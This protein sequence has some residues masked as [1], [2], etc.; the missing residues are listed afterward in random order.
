[1][2]NSHPNYIPKANIN[3]PGGSA[4]ASQAIFE[5]L[6]RVRQKGKVKIVATMADVAASGGVLRRRRR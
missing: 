1:M 3:S 2:L 6:M 4:A 5:E